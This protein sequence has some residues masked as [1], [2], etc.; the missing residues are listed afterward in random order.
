MAVR[1]RVG[2]GRL[3][4]WEG[5]VWFGV[6]EGALPEE[7]RWLGTS[8]LDGS[9][10]PSSQFASHLSQ[11]G[12]TAVLLGSGGESVAGNGEKVGWARERQQGKQAS[13]LPTGFLEVHVGLASP[14]P[15]TI[16]VG[17][18]GREGGSLW[19][20][21]AVAPPYWEEGL[22]LASEGAKWG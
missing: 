18:C 17:R 1:E 8:L 15:A 14:G 12:E 11:C 10:H 4:G 7:V 13:C 2:R 5:K 21:E 6:D 20:P 22:F 16:G 9:P 19:L 3:H